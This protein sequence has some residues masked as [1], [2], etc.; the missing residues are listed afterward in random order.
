[1]KITI[2]DIKRAALSKIGGGSSPAAGSQ[3]TDTTK[4]ASLLRHLANRSASDD[5]GMLYL[6]MIK[7]AHH[8]ARE[9]LGIGEHLSL[10]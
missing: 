6:D 10:R 1:M 9:K 8:K 3:N 5:A 4:L 2:N 7:E